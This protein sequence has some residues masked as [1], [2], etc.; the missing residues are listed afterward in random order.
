VRQL[1]RAL[2]FMLELAALGAFGLWGASIA[3]GWTAVLLAIGLPAF[4]AALW[5]TFAA[6]KAPRRLPLR[7]RAPFE[8][9]VLTVAALALWRAESVTAAATFAALALVNALGLTAFD[10]WEV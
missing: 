3:H 1:N 4:A 5:G 7:L 10:Q 8:L 2:K 6:P 9:G